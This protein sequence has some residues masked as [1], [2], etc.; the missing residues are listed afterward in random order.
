MGDL[1]LHA[2]TLKSTAST[3]GAS[4]CAEFA[5]RLEHAAAAGKSDEAELFLGVLERYVREV[6]RS[7]QDAH[8]GTT[9]FSPASPAA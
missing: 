7:I 3:I 1:D 4:Q 9:T 8:P 2:N 5:R 6:V